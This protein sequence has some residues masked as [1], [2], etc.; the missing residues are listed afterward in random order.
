MR[1]RAEELEQETANFYREA[2]KQVTDAGIRKLLVDLAE[3][4]ADHATT[5]HQLEERH[6]TEIGARE[7]G[8]RSRTGPSCCSTC[9]R[10]WPA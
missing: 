7:R 10:A 2:A 8:A 1:R 6:L 9:S 4:E 3:I 5:A